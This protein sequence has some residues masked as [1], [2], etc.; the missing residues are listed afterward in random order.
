ISPIIKID[1]LTE[2][3]IKVK[4]ER[5]L[6]YS[7][8]TFD[9]DVIMLPYFKLRSMVFALT[10]LFLYI[11]IILIYISGLYI[12]NP[13]LI[14][15]MNVRKISNIISQMIKGEIRVT[16][17]ALIYNDNIKSRDEIK[18]LSNEINNM[19]NILKGIVP[20]ISASTLQHSEKGES[21][22][23]EKDLTFLFTDIRG[24]TTLCEGKEPNEVVTILNKYL[25]LETEI[26]LKNGGDVDKF[27]GD[28]MM[29]FFDGPKRDENACRAAMEIRHAMMNEKDIREK[30][31]LPIVDI[32]IGINGGPVIFGSMGA[33]DRMDFTSIGDTVNLAARLEG[34]NKAYGSKSI[35]SEYVYNSVKDQFLC[36]ELDFITVKG[37]NEPV[38]IFEIIQNKNLVNKK[39]EE[40]VNLFEDGL[41]SYRNMDWNRAIELFSLNWEKYR[42]A[43]SKI[44][45]D[46]ISHFKNNPIP[47]NW[48]GVFRLTVK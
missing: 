13:I 27:V 9:K 40:I 24:F 11:S 6:G 10:A 12:V 2:N 32:G 35:I 31:G 43:P 18:T 46:R 23:I 22:S 28:E 7:I 36:R 42:D 48:D 26:I 25:D 3:D 21:V 14:L 34:A 16:P 41:K 4:K 15:R 38:R 47:E 45:I 37:K 1:T 19:V 30:E 8:I 39:L 5:L 44:F 29:A 33:R 17:S 20:Y